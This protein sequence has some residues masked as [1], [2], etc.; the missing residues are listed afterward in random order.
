MKPRLYNH[1]KKM[2][3]INQMLYKRKRLALKKL[4]IQQQQQQAPPINITI[5]N[6]GFEK[7]NRLKEIYRRLEMIV[8]QERDVARD[9]RTGMPFEEPPTPPTPPTPDAPATMRQWVRSPKGNYMV[10]Y[11]GNAGRHRVRMDD[12]EGRTTNIVESVRKPD[13]V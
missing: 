3:L 1:E 2:S 11:N 8:P 9:F 12:A 5:N 7:N 4:R 13:F 10:L 6:T